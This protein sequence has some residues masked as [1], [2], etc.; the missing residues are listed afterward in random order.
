MISSEIWNDCF[1]ENIGND[2][3]EDNLEDSTSEFQKP[4]EKSYTHFIVE[5]PLGEKIDIRLGMYSLFLLPVGKIVHYIKRLI[6]NLIFFYFPISKLTESYK[7]SSRDLVGLQLWRGAFLLADFIC[8]NPELFRMKNVLELAAGT[9]FTS[10]I[11]SK[12]ANAVICSGKFFLS[13]YFA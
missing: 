2:L 1:I 4:A 5:L 9:G 6:F 11:V 3:F 10:V 8:A 7:T 12:W 13:R